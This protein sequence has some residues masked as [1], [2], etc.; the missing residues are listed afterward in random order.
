[1][2]VLPPRNIQSESAKHFR[3]T[4]AERFELALRLGRR[5]LRLF[6]AAG[7]RGMTE[8]QAREHLRRVKHSGRRPSKVLEGRAG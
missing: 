6:L 1:M 3:G 7:G 4:P 5:S 2:S 8:L